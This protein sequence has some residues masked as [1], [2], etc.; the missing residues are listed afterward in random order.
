M[1]EHADIGASLV[2]PHLERSPT[3]VGDG[4]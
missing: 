4:R 3:V 1:G 2:H